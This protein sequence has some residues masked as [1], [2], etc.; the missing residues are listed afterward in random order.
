MALT[1]SNMLS[2]NSN[3]P[4]FKLLDTISGKEKSLKVL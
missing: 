3:A 1:Y 2:L 4:E